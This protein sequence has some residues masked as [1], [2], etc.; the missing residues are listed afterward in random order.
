MCCMG[1]GWAEVASQTGQ[2][3]LPWTHLCHVRTMPR[4]LDETQLHGILKPKPP[5]SLLWCTIGREIR[6]LTSTCASL[7]ARLRFILV[8]LAAVQLISQTGRSTSW[9]II[10]H[11]AVPPHS[12]RVPTWT[13]RKFWAFESR[14]PERTRRQSVDMPTFIRNYLDLAVSWQAPERTSPPALSIAH[15]AI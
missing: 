11:V 13:I 1:W 8:W 6:D 2:A 7:P 9:T 10:H 15:H 12:D 5:I 4:W 3:P 14:F